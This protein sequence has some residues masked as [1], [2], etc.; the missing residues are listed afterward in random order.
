MI[1]TIRKF[2]E[3]NISGSTN[4]ATSTPEHR[5][6]LATAAMLIEVMGADD[7]W[8]YA[9]QEAVV[10][11]L[12]QRFG[13]TEAETRELIE[14]AKQEAEGAT[15]H[16]QFTSLINRS[17]SI[18]EKVSLIE[19]LWVIAFADGH[20]DK[21]EDHAIRKLAELLYVDRKDFVI[22]KHRAQS[23]ANVR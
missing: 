5:L 23:A 6:Q 7:K 15:D 13:L 14:L 10:S 17:F 22:A 2:F 20:I 9:E 21:Y 16:Y 19:H 4:S 1:S 18:A 12:Q 3:Q 11:L 8:E